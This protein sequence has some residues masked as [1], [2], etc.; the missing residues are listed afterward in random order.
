MNGMLLSLFIGVILIVRLLPLSRVSNIVV[1]VIAGIVFILLGISEVHEKGWKAAIIA[2]A[3]VL[4]VILAFIPRLTTGGSYIA[5]T[6]I[7]SLIV[8]IASV[9]SDFSNFKKSLNKK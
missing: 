2:G 5:V 3:G 9:F 8:I 6:I 4:F 1:N 7:I